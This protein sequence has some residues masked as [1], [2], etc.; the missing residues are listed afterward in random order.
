MN[1]GIHIE[2]VCIDNTDEYNRKCEILKKII[3]SE[4]KNSSVKFE[5]LNQ[6]NLVYVIID[7]RIKFALMP[8]VGWNVYKQNIDLELKS[9]YGKRMCGECKGEIKCAATCNKCHILTCLECYIENF[10]SNK[11]IIRCKFCN[12]SFGVKVSDEYIDLAID[13]IRENAKMHKNK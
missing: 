3:K 13:D 9:L 4:Y 6:N 1:S 10:K 5:Q 12:Y 2:G 8:N 7:N 11:G